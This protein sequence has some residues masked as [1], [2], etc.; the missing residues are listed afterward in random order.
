MKKKS[1]VKDTALFSIAYFISNGLNAITVPI[2]TRILS[3]AD[4]GIW[5]TCS[6][7]QLFSTNLFRLGCQ[8]SVLKQFYDY[9]DEAERKKYLLSVLAFL[10]IWSIL[11]ISFAT[12]V[13][14]VIGLKQIYDISIWPFFYLAVLISL[15]TSI[16]AIFEAEIRLLGLAK[17]YLVLSLL[18]IGGNLVLSLFLIL[19]C[20]LGVLGKFIGSIAPYSLLA[21]YLA[22][23]KRGW[24]DIKFIYW[25]KAV[26]FGFPLGLNS[27]ISSLIWSYIY[28]RLN[29]LVA[30]ESVGEFHVARTFG[31]ILPD[32]AFQ[33][34]VLTY[35]PY[36]YKAL[37][38]KQSSSVIKYNTVFIGFLTLSVVL[39]FIFTRPVISIL[40]TDNYLSS[41][42]LIR[43][44]MI[45][46]ILKVFYYYPMLKMLSNNKSKECMY[47]QIFALLLMCLI[48]SLFIS[49]VGII[50][51]PIAIVA[52]ELTSL[53]LFFVMSRC[54]I[55]ELFSFE[56]LIN[57]RK[58]LK[59]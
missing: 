9:K 3:K 54:K 20:D 36:V 53:V 59:R 58:T 42:Y 8:Q 17:K 47:I 37:S 34:L 11:L 38:E 40:A 51:I 2:F 5:G 46:F 45:S 27:L 41:I 52:Q 39:Y 26:K 18:A 16:Y 15:F 14:E 32:Y 55:S 35:Q 7:I 1:W 21:I 33:A 12:L 28:I 50:I 57:I 6:N 44:L 43:I 31:L 19:K 56:Q 49:R 25:L 22:L 24:K 29:G 23:N 48:V 13:I 30:L 4:Y 10:T